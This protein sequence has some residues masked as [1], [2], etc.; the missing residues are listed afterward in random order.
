MMTLDSR[1]VGAIRG[2]FPSALHH[3]VE[4]ADDEYRPWR[5][6]NA[7]L[8]D[9]QLHAPRQ[10]HAEVFVDDQ[11]R[12]HL[13]RGVWFEDVGRC[14]RRLDQEHLNVYNVRLTCHLSVT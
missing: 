6:V 13:T 8:G 1:L 10:G 3:P 12:C 4:A 9:R 14:Q 7:D 11:L 5:P 2:A